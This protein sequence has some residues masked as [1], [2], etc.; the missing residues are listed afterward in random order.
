MP[1]AGFE[2]TIP[3]GER[4]QTHA[5]DRLA[6]RIGIYIYIYIYERTG[7]HRMQYSQRRI[8]HV[9]VEWWTLNASD[10]EIWLE[11]AR[12][13][14]GTGA[15]RNVVHLSATVHWRRLGA[16]MWCGNLLLALDFWKLDQDW[17]PVRQAIFRMLVLWSVTNCRQRKQF[18]S[19]SWWF[20]ISDISRNICRFRGF[21]LL[22][23]E[24]LQFW[25]I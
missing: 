20:P 2:P 15:G 12:L 22:L 23:R 25:R 8:D 7:A 11:S 4:L 18:F 9:Y 16:L 21:V 1:S 13:R 24:I 6:T 3:A 17:N 14:I 5:L 19:F 10:V